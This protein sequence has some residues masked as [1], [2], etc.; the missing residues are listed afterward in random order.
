MAISWGPY[1]ST[2]TQ[3]AR[4][5]IDL[6]RSDTASTSTITAK[7]YVQF[8][9]SV[10]DDMRLSYSGAL[11]GY[12]DFRHRGGTVHVSTK[13]ITRTRQYGSAQTVTVGASLSGVYN[14]L[15]PSHTASISVP[16]RAY[17]TP[18]APTSVSATRENDGRILVKWGRNSTTARPWQEVQVQQWDNVEGWNEEWRV[19]GGSTSL[20]NTGGVSANKRYRYRVRARNSAGWGAWAYSNYVYTTPAAPTNAKVTRNSD[21]QHTISWTANYTGSSDKSWQD[22]RIYRWDNVGGEYKHIATLTNVTTTS[23]ADKTTVPDRRYRYRIRSRNDTAY[24][25]YAYTPYISTTPAAPTNVTAAKSGNDIVVE[26]TN[27]ATHADGVEVWHAANGVWDSTPLAI[28]SG[29][30]TSYRHVNPD[31]TVTHTY[32]LRARETADSGPNLFS[33]YSDESNTIQLL[34]P[35][36]P[37]TG[38]TPDATVID[39]NEGVTLRWRHNPVDTTEQTAY[40]VQYRRQGQ[41]AWL[42]TGKVTSSDQFADF[43]SLLDNGQVYEWRVRTYGEHSS[44]GPYS[45]TALIV[46][47]ARPLASV[48]SPDGVVTR[49]TLTVEWSYYD[50]EGLDQSAWRATLY[51]A[52]GNILERREAVG[53]ATSHVFSRRLRNGETYTVGVAVRDGHSL[54]SHEDTYTF[55]VDYALPSVPVASAE[56]Q[57]DRGA[58]V[59]SVSNPEPDLD[60]VPTV[61]NEVWRS[62]DQ[63]TAAL[64]D[65]Y[66]EAVESREA[67]GLIEPVTNLVPNPRGR[68]TSGTVVVAENLMPDPRARQTGS[69]ETTGRARPEN[70]GALDFVDDGILVTYGYGYEDGSVYYV[71]SIAIPSGASRFYVA[72]RVTNVNGYPGLRIRF[73]FY[74]GNNN[75]IESVDSADLQPSVQ[76]S[77]LGADAA[78]PAGAQSVRVYWYGVYATPG[79]RQHFAEFYYGVNGYP[80]FFDGDSHHVDPDLTPEWVG[81]PGASASRLIA[82]SAAGWT[83]ANSTGGV[84]YYSPTHDAVVCAGTQSTLESS[85][86]IGESAGPR[87][88]VLQ[89]LN[90]G[91]GP[92]SIEARTSFSYSESVSVDPGEWVEARFTTN[93]VQEGTN[94][95]VSVRG[96]GYKKVAF[97]ALSV[98]GDYS[99]PFFDGDSQDDGTEYTWTG[100]P[101]ASASVAE[102]VGVPRAWAEFDSAFARTAV[103]IAREVAPNTAVTDHIPAPGGRN[104]Y[105]VVAY[106][107]LPS[108]VESEP[109]SVETNPVRGWAWLNAGPDFS[110]MVRFRDNLQVGLSFERAKALHRFAGRP[111]PVEMVGEARSRSISISAR[112]GPDSS[113]YEEIEAL[114]DLPA[115]LCYRDAAGRRFFVSVDGI[116]GSHRKVTRDVSITLTEVDFNE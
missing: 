112:L 59:V 63:E 11:G 64:L 68:N 6:T 69:W 106:S 54:W 56:W 51:D 47:S 103:L 104:T 116:S 58:V 99:G 107:D 33:A 83:I 42:S 70:N 25:A 91:D 29:Q 34:A 57:V 115:P 81:T 95:I 35:P 28:L 18:Y 15:S 13:T 4:V 3:S 85:I 10:N 80:S 105:R 62:P 12:T 89:V 111:F 75:L 66:H 110:Q 44:P 102:D 40:I 101:H 82:S 20:V 97:R 5:G 37:P 38:L 49:S 16:A 78:I 94:F 53:T 86:H 96:A 22:V 24:S 52:Q 90:L 55:D 36:G 93:G 100:D 109:F 31:S 98:R 46:T 113:T 71:P 74:D 19:S 67:H 27:A 43:S 108:S 77:R 79:E 114:A 84:R 7:F 26:W 88:H 73:Q 48:V 23:Y 65:A 50:E 17:E 60:E 30:P 1:K 32:R 8:T 9:Q 72:A 41:T 45:A 2:G 21:T 92:A 39:V 14:G 76:G 87:T 61:Y